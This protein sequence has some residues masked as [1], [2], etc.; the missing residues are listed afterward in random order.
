MRRREFIS[1]ACC[2]AAWPPMAHAQRSDRTR[3]I[4]VLSAAGPALTWVQEG[5]REG[6]KEHGYV[7][8]ENIHVEYRWAHGRF[9]QLPSLAAELVALNVDVIVSVVTAASLAARDATK[10][11]PIVMV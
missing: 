8:G 5:L 4:G 7:E 10:T 9:E 2:A 6:L 1:A 3:R 11:I